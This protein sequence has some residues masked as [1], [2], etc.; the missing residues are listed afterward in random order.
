MRSAEHA[1]RRRRSRRRRL[2]DLEPR[3]WWRTV[4]E[5]GENHC[6]LTESPGTAPACEPGERAGRDR[7]RG[8]G[9]AREPGP[10]AQGGPA[11]WASPMRGTPGTWAGAPGGMYLTACGRDVCASERGAPPPGRAGAPATG[12][13][14]L[15]SPRGPGAGDG[16]ARGCAQPPRAR[17]RGPPRDGDRRR[18]P[19]GAS[20]GSLSLGDCLSSAPAPFFICA[21]LGPRGA[22]EGIGATVAGARVNE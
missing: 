6:H 20:G 22:G 3:G 10:L 8:E 14:G 21:P 5:V 17:R 9:P 15:R 1:R 12:S 18:A 19:E 16:C 7:R 2:T 4:R 13:A 11:S